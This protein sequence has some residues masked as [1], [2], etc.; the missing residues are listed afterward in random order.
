VTARF[1]V[2]P[3]GAA[4]REAAEL[5]EHVR[6]TVTASPSHSLEQTVE[7]A[8][9]LRALGHDVTAHIAARMVADREHLEGLFAALS[10]A[11][12]DDAFVVGGD[13]TPPAG[14]YTSAVELLPVIAEHPQ[15]PA[16]LGITGYP[17]GHPLI[18][19][20]ELAEAL[21][22]KSRLADYIATQLCFDAK[23]VVDWVRATREAG[24]A[25]PVY[26][27]VPGM[28]DRRKL[29]EISTRVGVGASLR[30]LR[31]QR[32]GNLLRLSGSSADKL[33]DAL[34]PHMDD[35]QLNLCGFHYFTFNR[36]EKTWR[37]QHEKRG[38]A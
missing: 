11:G 15:R 30:Y 17:E 29:I 24:I 9:R 12:V 22:T 25:L 4:E 32:L 38:G 28:V 36:L 23:A 1:E 10:E 2:M 33:Y 13:A 19:S 5:P 35:P 8:T 18:D 27:G 31:K 37:W 20:T 3:F 6:L 14:P 21:R 7:V 34:A 26:V 16:T